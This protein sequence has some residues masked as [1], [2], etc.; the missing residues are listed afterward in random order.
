MHA[1]ALAVAAVDDDIGVAVAAAVGI[2]VVV[3]A[4]VAVVVVVVVDVVR[5]VDFS[6]IISVVVVVVDLDGVNFSTILAAFLLGKALVTRRSRLRWLE[7]R[8]AQIRLADLAGQQ[9]GRIL[10]HRSWGHETKQ[11][12]EE[13]EKSVDAKN[14]TKKKKNRGIG[15]RAAGKRKIEAIVLSGVCV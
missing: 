4:V 1:L 11:R 8:T 14:K 6:G 13:T 5:V 2:T 15:D 12:E 7:H 9:T 3:V 10:T